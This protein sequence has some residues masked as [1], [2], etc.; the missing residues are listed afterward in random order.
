M[1]PL[2]TVLV[3]SLPLALQ[4]FEDRYRILVQHCLSEDRELG[5]VLIERGSEVGGQDVR[6]DVGTLARINAATEL[7]DG[8]WAIRVVGVRRLRVSSWL[9]DDPYPRAQVEDW[10]DTAP[11]PGCNHKL[12]QTVARLRQALA[13][14]GEAGDLVA[15][16]TITLSDDCILASHQAVALAPIGP[17]D[18]HR[19][20]AAPTPDARLDDLDALLVETIEVLRFRLSEG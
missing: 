1:F 10:P 15:P 13:L 17:L 11:G 6:S 4:V 19:L 5:I 12:A 8:R 3:P 14:A 2:G 9:P 16:A 18:Q 20:L 7:P